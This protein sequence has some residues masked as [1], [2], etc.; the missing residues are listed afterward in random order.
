LLRWAGRIGFDVDPKEGLLES[1][2]ANAMG[3]SEKWV[4]RPKPPSGVRESSSTPMIHPPSSIINPSAFTLIELLVVIAVIA[5]LMAIL[6][7]ALQRVRGQARA[8]VCQSNLRQWGAIMAMS[9]NDNGGSFWSPNWKTPR[10]CY[11]PAFTRPTWGLWELTGREEGE[12][13][14]CCPMAPKF[15]YSEEG[16]AGGTFVAWNGGLAAYAEWTPYGCDTLYGSY[17]LNNAVGWNWLLDLDAPREKRIWRKADV[18]GQDRIPVLLDSGLQWCTSYFDSVGPSPPECDAMPTVMV[19]TP[20]SIVDSR[21]P[22]CI[23]R[24]NGGVN[25]LFTDWSVRKVGLKELWTLKWHRQFDP[26][27]KWTKAGSV[28]PEEW[29]RWMRGFKDY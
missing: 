28:Q 24:H 25:V 5:V 11:G 16:S 13:I 14:I 7:P 20:A 1:K 8:V 6:L 12:S 4:R 21:N 26:A 27:G 19:R 3:G 15:V 23:N 9:V 29:P 17:G 22:E 18:Q 10:S 2:G